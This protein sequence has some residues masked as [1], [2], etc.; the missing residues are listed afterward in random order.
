MKIIIIL[1]KK[2]LTNYSKVIYTDIFARIIIHISRNYNYNY[3]YYS[4]SHAALKIISFYFCEYNYTLLV[5]NY[6]TEIE[7]ITPIFMKITYKVKKFLYTHLIQYLQA[8]LEK[9]A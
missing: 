6:H 8:L 1:L 5:K 3:N 4:I 7:I 9:Q 2:Y